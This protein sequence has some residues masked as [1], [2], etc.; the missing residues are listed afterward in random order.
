MS[1]DT[2]L[3]GHWDSSPFD[4][5]VMEASELEFLDDGQGCGTISNALGD[6]VAP[7][8][9]HCPELGT[10]EVRD[11]FGDVERYHYTVAPALPPYATDP[12]PAVRFEPFLFY[13][14]EYARIS[15]ASG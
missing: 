15:T 2:A 5:G 1:L 7:F 9:W 14:R 3:I 13:A 11:E 6:Q 10:L 4:F 12:I 8:S